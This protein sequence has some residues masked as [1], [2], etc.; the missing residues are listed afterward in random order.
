MECAK[1]VLDEMCEIGRKIVQLN[2]VYCV[3]PLSKY[4]A[5]VVGL[6]RSLNV[7]TL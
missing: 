6:L 3:T 2:T 1:L 5:C 4:D 7:N